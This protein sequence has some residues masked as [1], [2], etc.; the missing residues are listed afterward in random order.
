MTS[1]AAHLTNIVA[2]LRAAIGTHVGRLARP[3]HSAW[4]GD[5]FFIEA[6]RTEPQPHVTMEAWGLL[7]R[8]LGRLSQRFTVLFDRWQSNTQPKPRPRRAR[9]GAPPSAQPD[10]PATTPTPDLRFPR[11]IG[12]V[13]HRIPESAPPTGQLDAML[14]DREPELRQFLTEA[15]Q[16]GRYLRPLCRA[17]GVPQPTWLQL[18]KRPKKPSPLAGE[19][20]VRGK[21]RTP[22][23]PEKPRWP[24]GVRRPPTHP[25]PMI[26]EDKPFRPWV[27]RAVRAAK[28]S[29]E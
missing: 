15:P 6:P 26:P 5:K 3:R 22:R 14:R 9:P 2:T 25:Y 21:P 17:L 18:P 23:Q 20:W 16:A 4:I 11:K 27:L 10:T 24:K 1:L 28:K 7:W 8:R 13:N 29:G 12:W 19:G